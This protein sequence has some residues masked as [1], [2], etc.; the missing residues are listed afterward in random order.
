M[1]RKIIQRNFPESSKNIPADGCAGD[2]V[3]L[4]CRRGYPGSVQ[5]KLL[6][7]TPT[8]AT[9]VLRGCAAA[10]PASSGA[11]KSNSLEA[12]IEAS[13]VIELPMPRY[14][15]QMLLTIA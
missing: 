4:K 6:L 12:L 3:C 2:Q 9:E 5:G 7:E 10:G 13:Y 8:N 15:L 1:L 11:A 14:S